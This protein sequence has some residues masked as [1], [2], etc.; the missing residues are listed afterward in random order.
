[1]W[2]GVGV[3]SRLKMVIPARQLCSLE[4]FALIFV[5]IF[6]HDGHVGRVRQEQAHSLI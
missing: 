2:L 4:E 3:G 1:M 6:P 5:S